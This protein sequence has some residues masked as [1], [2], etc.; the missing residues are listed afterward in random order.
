[1]NL[2]P[3]LLLGLALATGVMVL[4]GPTL[5]PAFAQSP[6]YVCK[7]GQNSYQTVIQPGNCPRGYCRVYGSSDQLDASNWVRMNCVTRGYYPHAGFYC[8]SQRCF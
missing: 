1:M 7:H 4:A 2:P 5:T 3:K 6:F 8:D